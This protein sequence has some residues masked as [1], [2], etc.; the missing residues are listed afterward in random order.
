MQY[1]AEGVDGEGN[2]AGGVDGDEPMHAGTGAGVGEDVDMQGYVESGQ[3]G[4]CRRVG[5][6]VHGTTADVSPPRGRLRTQQCARAR[7]PSQ[8]QNG[9]RRPT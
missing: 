7:R 8:I 1:G 2:K 6:D 9:S 5:D 4:V 3:P